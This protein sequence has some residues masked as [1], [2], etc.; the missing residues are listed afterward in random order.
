MLKNFPQSFWEFPKIFAYYAIHASHYA[1]ITVN[2]ET[3]AGLNIHS[4]S[5]MKFSREYFC[6][7]LA[8]S[9]YYST[10]AKYSQKNFRGTFK[11]HENHKR[12]AQ[13]IFPYI[14]YS[15]IWTTLMYKYY[16]LNILLEYLRYKNSENK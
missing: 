12:L 9:V 10:I 7:A 14:W 8:S 16:C 1:I 2:V 15:P 11:N 4:F 5:P 3:F 13:Q 6:G